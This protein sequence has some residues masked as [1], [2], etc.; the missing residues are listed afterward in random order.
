MHHYCNV[1]SIQQSLE[2]LAYHL[3]RVGRAFN[4][5]FHRQITPYWPSPGDIPMCIVFVEEMY[6]ELYKPSVYMYIYKVD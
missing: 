3:L 4:R 1:I 2:C 5:N 6:I